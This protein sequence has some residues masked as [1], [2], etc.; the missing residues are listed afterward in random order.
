[1]V[2]AKD[3]LISEE[4]KFC[5]CFDLQRGVFISTLISWVFWFTLSIFYLPYIMY[6]A[7]AKY[8]INGQEYSSI[9]EYN[10]TATYIVNE[11]STR[12]K[13][14]FIEPSC[15]FVLQSLITLY[16]IC[17]TLE[18]SKSLDRITEPGSLQ[19]L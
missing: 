13:I 7:P 10:R 15:R 8:L 16:R 9:E 6:L 2:A 17:Q 12:F 14:S 11:V 18:Q 19:P 4:P 1:M 3:W 5:L